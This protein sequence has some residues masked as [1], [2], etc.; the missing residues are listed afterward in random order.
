MCREIDIYKEDGKIHINSFDI[1]S[2]DW[3]EFVSKLLKAVHD[4]EEIKHE[5]EIKPHSKLT[6]ADFDKCLKAGIGKLQAIYS[7]FNPLSLI[8]G[9]P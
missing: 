9:S 8:S 5:Y 2:S 6:Q 1:D 3:D 7:N 4:L